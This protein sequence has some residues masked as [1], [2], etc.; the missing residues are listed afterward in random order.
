V[1]PDPRR[2]GAFLLHVIVALLAAAPARA[3]DPRPASGEA[4]ERFERGVRRFNEGDSAGALVEFLRAHQLKPEPFILYNIGLVQADLRR[5]VEAVA[6]LDQILLAGTKL[7][8][9]RLANAKRVRDEQAARVARLVVKTNAPAQIEIDNLEVGRAPL[10]HPLS[11]AA[12][13]RLLGVIAPGNVPVRRQIELPAGQT[14]TLE[15]DLL[16]VDGPLAQLTLASPVPGA[17]VVLDDVVVGRTPIRGALPITGGRHLLKLRRAGYR[18]VTQDL[19]VI[20][21]GSTEVTLE[22]E[23]RTDAGGTG[24][25]EVKPSE[26][27]ATVLVDGRPRADYRK[28]LRLA[29]GLHRLGVSRTGFFPVER[30]VISQADTVRS[31]QVTLE[32]TEETRQAHVARASG[33]RWRAWGTV[34]AGAVV[35][36]ASAFFYS[37]NQAERRDADAEFAAV[38]ATLQPGGACFV[39]AEMASDCD[40]RIAHANERVDRANQVRW[41]TLGGVAAGGAAVLVGAALLLTADNPDKYDPERRTDDGEVPLKFIAGLDLRGAHVDLALR[42]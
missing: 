40:Q 36:G 14:T 27:D 31:I 9:E 3:A 24:Q 6:A 17:D 4:A 1:K 34:A 38:E 19:S 21:G 23:E 13:V 33:Q 20:P 8:A 18:E 37:R 5:P 2:S 12:G 10:D 11:L 35:G 7:P 39:H 15:I 26:P 42:F 32:P 25:L 29:A 30:D 28:G 16:P 22:P 41:L